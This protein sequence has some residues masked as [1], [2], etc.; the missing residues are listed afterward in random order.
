MSM[1][2]EDRMKTPVIERVSKRGCFLQFASKYLRGDK[3]VVLAAVKQDGHAL[4]YAS[5]ALRA[6]KEVVLEAVKN[7]GIALRFASNALKND[8]ELVLISVKD[9]SHNMIYV[10]DELQRDKEVLLTAVKAMKYNYS[11]NDFLNLVRKDIKKLARE[12]GIKDFASALQFL[13]A[14]DE[15]KIIESALEITTTTKRK[16]WL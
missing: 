9:W 6:D 1:S 11:I 7:E 10:G 15:K 3:D 13:I 14:E 2:S 5:K 4:Y 8:K 16:E 12:T